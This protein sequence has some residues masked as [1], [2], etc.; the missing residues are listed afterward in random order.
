MLTTAR[1]AP[2]ARFI[3]RSANGRLHRRHPGCRRRVRGNMTDMGSIQRS[4]VAIAFAML[5]TLILP[6]VASASAAGHGPRGTPLGDQVAPWNYGPC[7]EGDS[8]IGA[9]CNLSPALEAKYPNAFGGLTISHHDSMI[10]VYM[11]SMPTGIQD[12]VD[13]IAPAD[14]VTYLPCSNTISAIWNVQLKI[15]ADEPQ[16]AASGIDVVGF[17]T[18]VVDNTVDVQVNHLTAAQKAQLD[19]EYGAGMITVQEGSPGVFLGGVL[20]ITRSRIVGKSLGTGELIGIGLG[21]VAL[22]LGGFALLQRR[23][24]HRA[25]S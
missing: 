20:S 16:L 2:Q 5:G 9:A 4:L 17:G 7:L 12:F 21:L 22:L 10:D 14:S 6:G 18:N 11:T 15:E 8:V 24:S 25:D 13:S 23:R 3:Q 19:Q 1:L